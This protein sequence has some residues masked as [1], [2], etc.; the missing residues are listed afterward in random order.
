MS[1]RNRP[2]RIEKVSRYVP[3]VTGLKSQGVQAGSTMRQ[4]L[5][6]IPR[7]K[8]L[9]GGD[10]DFYHKFKRLDDDPF[11]E[12]PSYSPHWVNSVKILPIT[13]RELLVER[14]INDGATQQQVADKLGILR[15]SVANLV[16]RLRVKRAYQALKKDAPH[17]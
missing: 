12:N 13:D 14:M 2:L 5:L 16:N 8:F 7:V 17:D 10:N 15:G 9:E 4:M 6:S 1:E 3:V 11:I